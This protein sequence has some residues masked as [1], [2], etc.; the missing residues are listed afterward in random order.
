MLKGMLKFHG[1]KWMTVHWV[2]EHPFMTTHHI[3]CFSQFS[4]SYCSPWHPTANVHM[5][6]ISTID[7]EPAIMHSEIIL[8]MSYPGK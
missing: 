6:H 3:V 7:L 4:F 8:R 1:E 2:L 5:Q